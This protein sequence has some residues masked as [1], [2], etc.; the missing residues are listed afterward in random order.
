MSQN[1]LL[2]Q[3]L[4]IGNQ[5]YNLCRDLSWMNS[6]NHEHSDRDGHVIG[7]ICN[8]KVH[9]TV[10]NSI[11][12]GVAP[13][14]WKMRNSFKKWHAY[15]SL[16]FSEAGVTASEQG[17][18]GKTIRPYL[19]ASMKSGT[20]KDPVGWDIS[21]TPP[22]QTQEWTYTQIASNPGFSADAQ[23]SDGMSLVDLY[24]LNICGVN[25]EDTPSSEGSL[26][27]TAV[28][29]IH[30]YNQDRMEVV[31]PTLDSQTV[32]GQNNPL[33]LLKQG[34]SVAGGEV[35][36]LAEDQE[37]EAPPYD[38]TDSGFS[39]SIVL[40]DIMQVN[41]GWNGSASVPVLKTAQ[42]F[43]PAGIL[44]L[45]ASATDSGASILIDVVGMVLCKDMA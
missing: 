1:T 10:A 34:G 44:K 27:Y 2:Y 20:I 43:V 28:G 25:Q 23:G 5:Y 7:Y 42:V 45:N 30:S 16:M 26:T 12:L 29:M 35:M 21:G 39:T 18:Y 33:A 11:S 14:T 40:S 36:E 38:I 22:A 19:D 13:N 6:I 37:L 24:D 3:D 9:G 41:P 15:R 17:R 8:L 32:E 4:A 31:T